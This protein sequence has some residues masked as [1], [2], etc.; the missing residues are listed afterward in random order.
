MNDM[1][2]SDWKKFRKIHTLALE[3]F[4][5][6]ILDE[7]AEV[8]NAS[9][10]TFHERYLKVYALIRN[11]DKEIDIIFGE[12]KRSTAIQSLAAMRLN[13][14]VTDD[15]YHEISGETRLIVDSLAEFMRGG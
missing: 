4:C 2:E 12:C 10:K 5:K 8:S 13:D 1:R 11:R 7:V 6:R 14:L 3:R 15:E 9:P